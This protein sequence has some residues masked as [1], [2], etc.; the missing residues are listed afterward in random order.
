MVSPVMAAN[1]RDGAISD[2]C[3]ASVVDSIFSVKD[4]CFEAP[5]GMIGKSAVM[6]M[7]SAKPKDMSLAAHRLMNLVLFFIIYILR[8]F[9]TG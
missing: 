7:P 1:S 4:R 9:C 5:A 8:R 6:H 2:V 3:M